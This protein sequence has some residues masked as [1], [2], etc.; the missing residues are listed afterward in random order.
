MSKVSQ[1]Y[2][3]SNLI[4]IGVQFG[5]F[6]FFDAVVSFVSFSMLLAGCVLYIIGLSTPLSLATSASLKLLCY[7][8]K[9]VYWD[10]PRSTV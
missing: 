7:G 6:G 5:V 10:I 4:Q 2:I 9:E 3:S 8:A 1:C